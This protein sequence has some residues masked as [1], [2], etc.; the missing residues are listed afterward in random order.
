MAHAQ[1]SSLTRGQ[2]GA[3]QKS[4]HPRLRGTGDS[5]ELAS[6][7]RPSA[8][9]GKAW[10]TLF[11]HAPTF[12]RGARGKRHKTKWACVQTQHT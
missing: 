7:P 10:Y 11:A 6:F 9:G 3:S 12:Y 4:R 2:V 1:R 8:G 5:I